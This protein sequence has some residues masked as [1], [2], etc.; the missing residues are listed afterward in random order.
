MG[1]NGK[2][3]AW[4]GV[5]VALLILLLVVCVV[6]ILLITTLA[7]SLAPYFTQLS[8]LSTTS[9]PTL[10]PS[11]QPSLQ[12]TPK[13]KCPNGNCANACLS[14]LTTFLQTSSV[15]EALPK[16][17]IQHGLG[18]NAVLLVTYHLHGD[19]LGSPEFSAKVPSSLIKL[20]QDTAPQEK[21][22]KYFA[23]IIP[24]NQRQELVAFLI[25]TDGRGNMLASVEQSS[26]RPQSWG[27]NVDIADA[28]QPR[29]LT[30]SLLHEFGHLL[31]LNESQVT[32]DLTYLQH[33]DDLQVYQQEAAL[34]PQYFTSEGCS[35]PNSYLNQFFNQF[36]TKL[37]PEWSK[38]NA[39][40]DQNNYSSLLAKFYRSH[41]TQFNTPY[42]A[43]SP[44]ED[45]AESWT[46][47]V[48]TP[49]PAN[50]SIAH[51]KLLFFY[52]FPELVDLRSQI[53]YGICNYAT[54]Q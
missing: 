11:L 50:D 8:P 26:Q 30:F 47:F 28:S 12:P 6:F 38:V 5:S 35:Q 39:V 16:S 21:I 19:Q 52:K 42:S 45:I 13:I 22:W 4:F 31:T 36:W 25:S 51:Q 20:Q 33:R 18:T 41:P 17:S 49:K 27:L 43:T 2:S 44:E 7:P 1:M 14:Q 9:Q 48:L 15:P 23:A 40:K 54:S 10:Q 53:I 24:A 32:P 3:S 29:D 46:Y 37:Y 34:C